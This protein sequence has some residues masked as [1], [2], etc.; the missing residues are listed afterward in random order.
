[1]TFFFPRFRKRT[2][3]RVTK[4]SNSN[5]HLNTS[6]MS[7][8]TSLLSQ[9]DGLKA[10]TL[11]ATTVMDPDNADLCA[12]IADDPELMA[13]LRAALTNDQ[14]TGEQLARMLTDRVLDPALQSAQQQRQTTIESL[15]QQFE[16]AKTTADRVANNYVLQPRGNR[17][18]A[19][20]KFDASML[21]VI[22][23]V[24]KLATVDRRLD[25]VTAKINAIT[26]K[27]T[28]DED[29]DEHAAAPL[30]ASQDDNPEAAQRATAKAI[31][32]HNEFKTLEAYQTKRAQLTTEQKQLQLQLFKHFDQTLG[33]MSAV[34]K[35]D[36]NKLSV[37]TLN[38]KVKAS[39]ITDAFKAY[40]RHRAAEY[41]AILP[42]MNYAADS[43]NAEDGT[44]IVT[45]DKDQKYSTVDACLLTAYD[46]QSEL[47]Y[48]EIL[49]CIGQAEMAKITA[50]FRCGL[51]KQ[52]KARTTVGDGVTAF[53]NLLAKHGK[54]DAYTITGT[55]P[56]A[57]V[58]H[59]RSGEVASAWCSIDPSKKLARRSR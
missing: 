23:I 29:E 53:R 1:M 37:P 58:H 9:L 7:S 45:P 46:Q 5:N 12:T 39:D 8:H 16:Q 57:T 34:S 30:A 26:Y 6:N 2:K 22:D 54:N 21:A 4:F 40:M 42:Y 44:Y 28:S 31:K 38:N 14:L 25:R 27:D 41:Y 52:N 24:T 10:A 47:L 36:K 19:K 18:Q 15:N 51:N 56:Q 35:H 13:Q 49:S 55:L 20:I 17:A 50:T 3:S 59:K 43:Y 48:R 32:A 33:G 11:A